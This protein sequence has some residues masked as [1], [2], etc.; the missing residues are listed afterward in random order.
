MT[1]P[2]HWVLGVDVVTT[3]IEGPQ[4]VAA[5]HVYQG[6][7]IVHHGLVDVLGCPALVGGSGM[8]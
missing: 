8:V 5:F 1:T 7:H 2:P 6:T 3:W 4:H